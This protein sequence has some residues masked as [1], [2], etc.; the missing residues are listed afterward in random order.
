MPLRSGRWGIPGHSHQAEGPARYRRSRLDS[1][2]IERGP[3]LIEDLAQFE[4]KDR[5]KRV[6]WLDPN[7]PCPIV[8]Y[9]HADAIGVGFI[10]KVAPCLP[11]SLSVS[12]TTLARRLSAVSRREVEEDRGH[13]GMLLRTPKCGSASFGVFRLNDNQGTAPSPR[14]VICHLLAS[15]PGEVP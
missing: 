6:S 15:P 12:L 9:M 7:L 5:R 1:A 3:E 14:Q 4:A 8:L 13:G 11:E 2:G 10:K